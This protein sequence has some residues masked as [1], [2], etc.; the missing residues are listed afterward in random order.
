MHASSATIRYDLVAECSRSA[1]R[2]GRLHTRRGVVQTPVF[3]PVGT[4]ATVKALDACDLESLRA[5]II[6]CNTYHLMLRPGAELVAELGGL[7]AFMGYDG[8]IL[9][10]SGGFQVFSLAHRRELTDDG[11]TFRSHLDGS[12]HQLTPER[13]VSI[14]EQLGSTVA[15]VLDE[16][17]PA[18]ATRD[19]VAR[20]VT[21]SSRW[22]RRCLHARRR[23][24]VAWFGIV[25]G[26]VFEDLR[27]AHAEELNALPFDGMAI[28]GVSVGESPEAMAQ[29]V[30]STAPLLPQN[31]PRY[32]MGVGKPEDLVRGV[33]AGIDMFD[34]VLP[35]RNARNGHLY[36]HAGLLNIKNARFRSDSE[37]VDA[38]C[39]CL[40]CRRYSRAYLRHLYVAKELTFHRLATLHNLTFYAELMAH[41]RAEIEADSFAP[42]RWLARLREPAA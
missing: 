26:G 3:M 33:A 32:L 17:P 25:Q 7:H 5:R 6:L 30:S 2:R 19:E 21:R 36:T 41:I 29:V 31:K 42:D 11:V 37:P 23:D 13:A 40:A 4:L 38:S 14:Q 22:A 34:C 35:T 9:T 28:G 15:M 12:L 20:A 27:R 1:A 8:A 16:C 39:R 18:N 24:D 10:D